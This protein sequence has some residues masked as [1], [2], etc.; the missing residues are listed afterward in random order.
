MKKA[1]VEDSVASSIESPGIRT[2]TS[3]SGGMLTKTVPLRLGV[4]MGQA[5]FRSTG[6]FSTDRVFFR[7][8]EE[9]ATQFPS[10][11]LLVPVRDATGPG[12]YRVDPQQIAVSPLPPLNQ[13]SPLSVIACLPGT[14]RAFFAMRRHVD[15]LWIGGPHILGPLLVLL[16]RLTRLP[17]FLVIR[18]NLVEQV[19][20]RGSGP[21]ARLSLLVARLIEG[22]FR[23]LA[24][25][26]LTL[27]VGQALLVA[28]KGRHPDAPVV[29]I[30]VSMVRQKLVASMGEGEGRETREANCRRLLAVGRLSGEKGFDVLLDAV[31]SMVSGGRKITL[32]I[33]GEGPERAALERRITGLGLQAS[34]TLHGYIP[35]GPTLLA[36][37][38]NADVFVLPSRSG[39]GV[40]QVLLE[41]MASSTPVVASA[42]EGVPYLIDDGMN[43]LLV[44]PDAPDMLASRVC[45]VLDDE[46]LSTALAREGHAFV[47][48]HT[49]ELERAHI[50]GT[51]V[52]YWPQ[53]LRGPALFD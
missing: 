47:A 40:P 25:R 48:A 41:A 31:S 42:V 45:E 13:Y 16:C 52:R 29:P 39:E 19:R 43:G 30:V 38:R 15:L 3:C 17:Y 37:Y 22:Y 21:K 11:T 36:Y 10:T 44:P 26:H 1:T 8:L 7:F 18:Q 12:P 6:G 4:F 35:F 5:F 27:V 14:I 20:H 33:V 2:G 23:H 51:L 53:G 28:Y 9:I 32:D 50:I 46:A 34:V 49:L 24:K